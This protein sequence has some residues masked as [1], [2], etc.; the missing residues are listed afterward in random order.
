MAL[1]C[2]N[3]CYLVRY[4]LLYGRGGQVAARGQHVTRYSV[5][6]GPR[7]D[8]GRIIKSEI[9]SNFASFLLEQRFSTWD[10][11][12]YLEYAEISM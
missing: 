1:I 9:S 3:S 7:K 10:R 2:T 12:V 11:E 4:W 8:S 5:F 6:I